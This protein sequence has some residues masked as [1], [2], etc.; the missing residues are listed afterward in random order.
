MRTRRLVLL[1]LF[2]MTGGSIAEAQGIAHSFDELKLLV[3]SGDRA[4][5]RE[6][7]EAIER[8]ARR[9]V[10]PPGRVQGAEAQQP[11]QDRSWIKRHQALFGALVGAGVGA[12]SSAGQW[13][14]L[15]CASGGDEECVFHGGVGVLFG[16]GFGAGIGALVGYLVGK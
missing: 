3:K 4:M 13:N 8:E 1:A 16:A 11:S 5:S 14:E 10:L 12:V 6:L 2:F 7:N 9:F 15:Y